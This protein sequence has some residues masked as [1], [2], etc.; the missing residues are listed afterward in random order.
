VN[1]GEFSNVTQCDW[2]TYLSSISVGSQA[3]HDIYSL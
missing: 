1:H 3:P 2:W